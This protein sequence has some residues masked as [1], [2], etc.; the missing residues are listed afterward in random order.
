[1]TISSPLLF[2]S[3]TSSKRSL[4]EMFMKFGGKRKLYFFFLLLF[5][6]SGTIIVYAMMASKQFTRAVGKVTRQVYPETKIAI[7]IKGQVTHIIE[8]FNVSRAAGTQSEQAA[9]EAINKKIIE[10][11][12]ELTRLNQSDAEAANQIAAAQKTYLSS[13]AAGLKMVEASVNQEYAE[14]TTWT[15]AFDKEN[16]ILRKA[17]AAITEKSSA[18][19]NTAMG[20]VLDVSRRLNTILLGSIVL[21]TVI[22]A[23]IFSMIARVSRQLDWM[24]QE[25]T[26][27]TEG[28]MD[29]IDNINAMSIQLATETSSSSAALDSISSTMTQMTTQAEENLEAARTAESAANDLQRTASRS[30]GSIKDVVGAMREVVDADKEISALVKDIEEIAF[31]TNLLALNAAVEAARAGEAGAGFAVVAAEVRNLATRTA[32]TSS[33]VAAIIKRLDTKV[34]TG[35]AMVDTLKTSFAEVSNAADAVVFQMTKIMETDKRQSVTEE[36]IRG[37]VASINDMVQSQAAMSQEASA[38][39]QDVKEQVERLHHMMHTLMRFWEGNDT[40]EAAT[41]A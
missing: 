21:L 19:H 4:A 18:S 13:F 35:V 5:V 22:G 7:E 11:F 9:I 28:L 37:S 2:Y 38:T 12:T 36:K 31:Q 14:E 23:I 40:G 41:D 10:Q 16:D 26:N 27:A 15:A 3:A 6:V 24:G 8:K 32:E 33:M 29:A 17:L 39:V 20:H 1:M 25:S 34:T 30:S